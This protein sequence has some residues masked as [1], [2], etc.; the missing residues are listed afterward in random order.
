M[1]SIASTVVFAAAFAGILSMGAPAQAQPNGS[2]LQTCRNVRVLGEGGLAPLVGL[3]LPH[4]DGL[5]PVRELDHVAPAPGVAADLAR[6]RTEPLGDTRAPLPVLPTCGA[7]VG[8]G[9]LQSR[10]VVRQ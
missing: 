2:Y 4:G 1:R 10:Q 9:R 3:E 8:Q 5:A 7:D 6:R